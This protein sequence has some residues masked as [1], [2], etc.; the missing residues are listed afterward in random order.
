MK[1]GPGNDPKKP[2]GEMCRII[3]NKFRDIKTQTYGSDTISNEMKLKAYEGA[4]NKD[5]DECDK[6]ES[7][8]GYL[9][10]DLK[11]IAATYFGLSEEDIK[12]KNFQKKEICEHISKIIKQIKNAA[13]DGNILIEKEKENDKNIR[14]E[15]EKDIG[16]DTDKKGE[17]NMIYT[18]DIKL[19]KD[20][21]NRGGIGMKELKRIA[22]DNFGIDIQQK[23]KDQ[24]CDAIEH[25]LKAIKKEKHKISR[26][27]TRVSASKVSKFK[28]SF[29][30][31][32]KSPDD[33][34][35]D[36]LQK[37]NKELLDEE[38]R[39]ANEAYDA[40]YN[41]DEE[42]DEEHE[43]SKKLSKDSEDDEDDDEAD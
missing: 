7:K 38:E 20:T 34:I 21:P 37:S 1:K 33:A 4:D 28:Y 14:K 26:R 22:I 6:G 41:D 23:S 30:D 8:G 13:D 27:A 35:D 2:K 24:I 42:D 43:M 32:F 40:Q 36:E 39:D 31:L 15:N 5:I 12:E 10:R 16:K 3:N 11:E 25:K 19:C 18:R 29:D 9:L 17:K